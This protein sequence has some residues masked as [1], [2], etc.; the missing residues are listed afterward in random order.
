MGRSPPV[1]PRAG[2][3]APDS[4]KRAS[5]SLSQILLHEHKL[6]DQYYVDHV[7]LD[8][9]HDELNLIRLFPIMVSTFVMHLIEPLLLPFLQLQNANPC[10]SKASDKVEVVGGVPK[11][12]RPTMLTARGQVRL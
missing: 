9:S 5:P 1:D 12:H 2:Q 6:Q 8:S 4:A 3:V 11:R 10:Y 7:L